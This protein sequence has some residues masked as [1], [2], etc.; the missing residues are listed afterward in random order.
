MTGGIDLR[1]WQAETLRLTAFLAEPLDVSRL[2]WWQSIVGEPPEMRTLR[3]RQDRLEESGKVGNGVCSLSLDCNPKRIDWLLTPSIAED[4][5]LS[6]FPS[7]GAFPDAL[8]LFRGLLMPWLPECPR[9]RRLAFGAVLLHP[10][11]SLEAGY[12]WLSTLLPSIRLD[13]GASSDFSYSINRPRELKTDAGTVG[14]N[15]L[16]RWSAVKL[17]GILLNVS[18]GIALPEPR[19]FGRDLLSCRLEIDI[20][21]APT[22]EGDFFGA[23]AATMTS[24]LI[25]IGCEL[26][27]RGDVP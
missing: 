14:I 20:N 21:T 10:V 9:T 7:C 23:G 4:R 13:P 25:D 2:A 18:D 12:R 22:F 17:S 19:A 1:V 3:P 6:E 8:E 5:E 15:R 11:D 26:A 24:K 27:S 16:S